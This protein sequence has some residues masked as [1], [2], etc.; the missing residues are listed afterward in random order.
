M[1]AARGRNAGAEYVNI[2]I[3]GMTGKQRAD[4]ASKKYRSAA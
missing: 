4:R 1:L 2:N 3:A